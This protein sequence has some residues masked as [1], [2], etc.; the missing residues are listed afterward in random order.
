MRQGPPLSILWQGLSRSSVSVVLVASWTN[1]KLRLGK[2]SVLGLS[3]APK[4]W[5]A[6]KETS[7]KNINGSMLQPWITPM[8]YPA[9]ITTILRWR[10]L[11][12]RASCMTCPSMPA[13]SRAHPLQ[14]PI[15]RH[16]Q[17]S[18]EDND[19]SSTSTELERVDET[20]KQLR[21]KKKPDLRKIFTNSRIEGPDAGLRYALSNGREPEPILYRKGQRHH[22]SSSW[23]FAK[24]IMGEI[25]QQ[26]NPSDPPRI[27]VRLIK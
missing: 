15:K 25:F 8:R 9:D 22:S 4:S 13:L 11:Q 16:L 2:S 10:T 21:H 5:T 1:S 7:L 6:G 12:R 20:L 26:G 3:D 14:L 19:S 18:S 24:I 23:D 17:D 27:F